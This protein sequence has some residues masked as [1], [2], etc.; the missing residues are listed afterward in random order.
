MSVQ[1]STRAGQQS[2]GNRSTAANKKTSSSTRDAAAAAT[3]VG[4][5][6][7]SALSL[8]SINSNESWLLSR[9]DVRRPRT[10][11]RRC[12]ACCLCVFNSLLYSIYATNKSWTC[13]RVFSVDRAKSNVQELAAW[14]YTTPCSVISIMVFAVSLRFQ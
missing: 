5:P 12:K 13:R 4:R 7:V 8:Q 1:L 14:G 2:I 9:S 3:A 11:A 10:L 6:S